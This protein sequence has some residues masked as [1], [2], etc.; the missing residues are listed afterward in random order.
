MPVIGLIRCR[1]FPPMTVLND[2]ASGVLG[3]AGF[4]FAVAYK[5]NGCLACDGQGIMPPRL[6]SALAVLYLVIM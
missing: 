2:V 6:W 1:M 3:T 5:Y 4:L